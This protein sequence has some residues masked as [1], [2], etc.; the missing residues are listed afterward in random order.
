MK[1]QSKILL[2]VLGVLVVGAVVFASTNSGLFQGKLMGGGNINKAEFAKMVVENAGLDIAPPCSVFSYVPEDVWFN[3][4]VCTLYN[5]GIVKGYVD[6]TFG[7]FGMLIRA[8]AAKV[9]HEAFGL[10]YS[11]KLPKLFKDVDSNTWYYDFINQ[12]AAYDFFSEDVQ[13][14]SKF[15]P[16]DMLT[17]AAAERWFSKSANLK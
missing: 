12:L 2:A 16:S 11:C 7:P 10:D 8:E 9:V 17:K 6:G 13:I 15:R 14:G 5:N 4:Y 1:K 3:Q